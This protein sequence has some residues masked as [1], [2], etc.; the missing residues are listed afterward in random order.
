MRNKKRKTTTRTRIGLFASGACVALAITVVF[1]NRDVG[2]GSISE[3]QQRCLLTLGLAIFA[4]Q[5]LFWIRERKGTK[6][7]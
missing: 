1:G 6:T 7:R 3:Y 4:L 2:P 5:L